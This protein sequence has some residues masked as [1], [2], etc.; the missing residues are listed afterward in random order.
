VVITKAKGGY[1]HLGLVFCQ[2]ELGGI[3]TPLR[4]NYNPRV[5]LSSPRVGW[6]YNPTSVE[7]RPT[8][9]V[10]FAQSWVELQPD[11]GG[12]TTRGW[13]EVRPELGGITTPLRWNDNPRVG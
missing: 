13:G 2:R 7:L 5:R 11:F 8:D 12:I 3:T 4:W 6:N 1:E 9:G 10:K